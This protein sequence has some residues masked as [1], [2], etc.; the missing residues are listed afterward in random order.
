MLN[1]RFAFF[2]QEF[3]DFE[4]LYLWN[5]SSYQ[6]TVKSFLFGFQRSFILANK[7]NCQKFRCTGTLSLCM[8]VKEFFRNPV[9]NIGILRMTGEVP[10]RTDERTLFYLDKSN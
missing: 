3:R 5:G 10:D 2:S 1:F 8:A 9:L 6:Q 7:R 4:S